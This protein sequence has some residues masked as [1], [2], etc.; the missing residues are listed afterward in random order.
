VNPLAFMVS[1]VLLFVNLFWEEIK[2]GV[3][4]F[5]EKYK[6]VKNLRVLMLLMKK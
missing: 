4:L 5:G 1:N 6:K 3:I 2:V